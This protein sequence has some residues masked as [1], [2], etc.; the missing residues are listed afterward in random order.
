MY[1]RYTKVRKGGR[2]DGENCLCFSIF[3]FCVGI[4]SGWLAVRNIETARQ[5]VQYVTRVRSCFHNHKYSFL[6]E[7]GEREKGH[8]NRIPS[9][10][11]LKVAAALEYND[12]TTL[13]MMVKEEIGVPA[14]EPNKK[15]SPER[16]SGSSH[17]TLSAS[18]PL[19]C[20]PA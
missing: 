3:N 11:G 20:G 9:S 8:D 7:R 14:T 4:L 13:D 5:Y 12:W 16:D 18:S 2:P 17:G 6:R 19:G 15:T 1:S 10:G